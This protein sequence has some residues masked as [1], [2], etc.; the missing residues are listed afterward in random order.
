MRTLTD[1]QVEVGSLL[2]DLVI[3]L[4]PTVIVSTALATMDFTPV[5]HDVEGARA[6]GSKDIFLNI[7]TTMGLVERYVTD[8][9]GPEALIRGINVKLGAPAYAGD[10]LTFTGTVAACEDGEFTVEIR[11][12]VSL[13]DHASGTVRFVLPGH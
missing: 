8:W 4:S 9:A 1:D 6:Q 5:H 3:E 13:G 2:P 12:R 11:G 7:L 10:T